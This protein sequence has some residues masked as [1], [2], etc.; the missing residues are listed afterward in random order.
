MESFRQFKYLKRLDPRWPVELMLADV[1][2]PRAQSKK[3]TWRRLN[4]QAFQFLSAHIDGSHEQETT[5]SSEP[6]VCGLG[7]ESSEETAPS[8]RLTAQTPEELSAGFLRV[9]Y[10]RG[11][12][13]TSAS[14]AGDPNGPASDPITATALGQTGPGQCQESPGPP[15]EDAYSETSDPLKE[16]RTYVGLGSVKTRATFEGFSGQLDARVWDVPPNPSSDAECKQNPDSS[17]CPVLITRGTYRLRAEGG[18]VNEPSG[19]ELLACGQST[20]EGAVGAVS[21]GADPFEVVA[22]GIER[23]SSCPS[24]PPIDEQA[25]RRCAAPGDERDPEPSECPETE[26]ALFGNHWDLKRGHRLRLDPSRWT[27]RSP[28]RARSRAASSSRRRRLTC[29]HARR[30]QR[31]CAAQPPDR[32]AAS[33]AAKALLQVVAVS[34]GHVA[35]S[36]ALSARV[37]DKERVDPDL[38]LP[39]SLPLTPSAASHVNPPQ[40]ALTDR[41]DPQPPFALCGDSSRSH[42]DRARRGPGARL[43]ARPERIRATHAHRHSTVTPLASEVRLVFLAIR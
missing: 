24:V 31:R 6:T 29:R 5:V 13:L 2:H 35:W 26:I 34:T 30:A 7:G 23:A 38:L 40:D 10:R 9:E 18:T 28:D 22:G 32:A 27:S 15:P 3:S 43:T 37:Q 12:A 41:A 16:D 25:A 36:A 19:A 33:R 17:R 21:G 39:A 1:G 11:D 8:G 14:G 20:I 4:D 42:V